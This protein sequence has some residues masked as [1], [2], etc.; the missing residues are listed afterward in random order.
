M[1]PPPS[2]RVLRSLHIGVGNRGT[3][4]LRY[5]RPENGFQPVA[6]CD[7][8]PQ[9]LEQARAAT[10]LAA[11]DC[12]QE[13]RHAL[14]KAGA[15]CAIICAPTHLHLPLAR[16]CAEAGLSI[17][18]EKG[19]APSWKEAR[20]LAACIE[21]RGIK[22]VVAQNFRYRETERAI[23]DLLRDASH[24]CHLGA[25]S[26]AV[27]EHQ[28]VRPN[29]RNLT[30]PYASVWDMSC[31]HF[32]TLLAWLGPL[33]SLQAQA[34]GAPW[35]AYAHPNN[36]TAHLVFKE[37]VHVHYL[38]THDAARP[39]LHVELHGEKGAAVW[40]D[41]GLA[42]S[43]RPQHNFG[44]NPD[45]PLP[46]EKGAGEPGVLDDFHRY[47]T[48]GIEPGISVRNNLEVMAACQMTVL[49]IEEKRE[50]RRE[51]LA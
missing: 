23:A 48:E 4:P 37:G 46:L 27:Y 49:S 17:L 36:T 25:L 42:F 29:P 2:K 12:H 26:F 18:M 11:E 34:W 19:M 3:W 7:P 13:V 5:A 21:E 47:V 39:S 24:P 38:H 33:E 15:D 51:E 6:L 41:G 35:S 30:Y 8:N 28:R 43:P 44:K 50:V 10:G 31:H 40:T 9:A 16:Q 32:D 20:E 1:Q 14:E 45:T 22:A